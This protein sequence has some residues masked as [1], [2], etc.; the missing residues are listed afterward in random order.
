MSAS[1]FSLT[2]MVPATAFAVTA[3]SP[4]RGGIK[5]PQLDHNFCPDCM[6]W[7]FTRIAGVS[8]FVNVRPTMLDDPRW[9]VPFIE[10]VTAEKLPWVATPARHSYPGYPPPDDYG[11]L[12]AAF[13]ASL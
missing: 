6:S 10:T 1:A 3:G 8:D 4:V 2:A 13:A 7:M 5:G 12:M 9:S 11:P